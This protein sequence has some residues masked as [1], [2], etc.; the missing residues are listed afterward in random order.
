MKEW[1]LLV[2]D[3]LCWRA[4]RTD[5]GADGDVGVKTDLHGNTCAIVGALATRLADG[6]LHLPSNLLIGNVLVALPVVLD[7]LEQALAATLHRLVALGGD[8]NRHRLAST[9]DDYLV[10][11][12]VD[13]FKGSSPA[14]CGPRRPILY[15]SP[16]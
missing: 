2:S 16:A 12:V 4:L 8:N 15:A 13:A 5:G 14:S 11:T 6:L 7:G 9:L 3:D 10:A 1:A